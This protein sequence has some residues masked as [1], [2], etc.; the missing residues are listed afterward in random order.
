[1]M[2]IE[3]MTSLKKS[4]ARI[5]RRDGL[6]PYLAQVDGDEGAFRAPFLGGY[7]PKGWKVVARYFVDNSGFG[8]EGEGAYTAGEFLHVVKA[9]YGYGIQEAGQFQ[10]Y[11]REYNRIF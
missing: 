2:S 7:V 1:M 8:R 6:V 3:A 5:A 9:G 11:V 10:V 4:K